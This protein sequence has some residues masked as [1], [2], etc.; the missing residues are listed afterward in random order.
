[1]MAHEFTLFGYD[2]LLGF[3]GIGAIVSMV[4]WVWVSFGLRGHLV[5]GLLHAAT[6]I[7]SVATFILIDV[8]LI[9]GLVFQIDRLAFRMMIAFAFGVQVVAAISALL[10]L[11]Q[12]KRRRRTTDA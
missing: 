5:G 10:L 1:M 3:A 6:I 9:A 11:R 2:V 12:L 4:M 8:I 7:L